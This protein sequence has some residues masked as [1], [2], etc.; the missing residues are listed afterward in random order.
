MRVN[1]HIMN[2]GRLRLMRSDGRVL[3]P[4]E[5]IGLKR[6]L[7]LWSGVQ[8]SHYLIDGNEVNVETCV[9]PSLDMVAVRI[10][11]PLVER[12]ELEVA[13]DFAYPSMNN[14]A[15]VGDF[16]RKTGHSTVGTRTGDRRVDLVRKVDAV[17]YHAALMAGEGDS[18]RL[19]S[20]AGSP[21]Q[22]HDVWTVSARGSKMLSFVCAYSADPLPPVLPSGAETKTASAVRWETFWKSGGAIDLSGSSDA[23]WKELERRI[24]LSQFL[25]A[26]MS[27][28]GW[29][30][31]ENGLVGIDP[32]HGRFH[33]EM[34]W[35]HLAHYAL[36]EQPIRRRVALKIIK[37]GMDTRNVIARFEAERQ[38]LALMDHPNIARSR[39]SASTQPVVSAAKAR[40]QKPDGV[41]VRSH[42]GRGFAPGHCH[43]D[44]D[45]R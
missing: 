11:S 35:W 1:P 13:L 26:A 29:P 18:I 17:T 16:N 33:M 45:V 10:E 25:M 40:A 41:S 31:S 38:A 23:R 9:H 32:W 30:S 44:N 7:D 8:T 39:S 15:W 19:P 12:G 42:R 43:F 34:V 22:T 2:L 27:A 6:S 5:V 14:G 28:G 3:T 24:V 4:G 37:L 36:Q 20:A 21:Q